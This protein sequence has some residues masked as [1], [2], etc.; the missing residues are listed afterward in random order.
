ME[1]LP[2]RADLERVEFATSIRGYD[3]DEV[4]TFMRELAEEHNRLVAE[5]AAVKRSAE[6]A[7]VE[8]GEEIGDL[9]QHA[10][11]VADQM[12]KK[13]EEDAA[14]IKEKARRA[15]EKTTSEAT[16]RAEDLRRA[17]EADAVGRLRDAQEKVRLLQETEKQIRTRLYSVR[18]TVQTLAEQIEAAEAKPE[19]EQEVLSDGEEIGALSSAGS[20]SVVPETSP[21]LTQA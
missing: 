2:I 18:M 17:A 19:V 14:T 13:A 8:L 9:L 15:A 12:R 11:D 20:A 6:K 1:T 4:D 7:Y 3:K 10:K 5:L 21:T 16:R